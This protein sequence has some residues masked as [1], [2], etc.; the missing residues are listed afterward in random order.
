MRHHDNKRKFGR[1]TGA[2]RALLNSLATNLILRG[3]INTTIARAKE[4]RPYVE[5]M[6]TKAKI[7][8]PA[9]KRQV[10]SKLGSTSIASKLNTMATKEYSDRKGGYLR[11]TRT[12]RRASDSSQMALIEF[13]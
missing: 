2:R 11:I 4:L 1:K 9:A 3:K 10:V 13:M 12:P 7:D 8:S 6:I 5:K